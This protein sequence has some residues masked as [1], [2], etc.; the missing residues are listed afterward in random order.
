MSIGFSASPRF[1]I[2]SLVIG[3]FIAAVALVNAENCPPCYKDQNS[4]LSVAMEDGRS[5][6]NVQMDS[7]WNVDNA[8]NPQS[9]TNANIWN[10]VAGCEG[11]I[12][13]QGAAGMWNNAQ[14]TGG[15][16]IFFKF[17]RD[18][19]S[20]SPTII[21]KRGTP[22]NGGCASINLAPNGGP[23]EMTLP[24]ST[25]SMDLW[26]IVER[27]AHEFGHPIG[28]DNI[29]D[30]NCG[31]SSIMSPG[32]PNCTGQV[33]RSVTANDVDQSRK[34]HSFLTRPTV[35]QVHQEPAPSRHQRRLLVLAI[36]PG[37]R[38]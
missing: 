11:C 37:F 34:A 29:T 32:N 21:I 17:K 13:P 27:I 38:Q 35:K 9:S 14:G 10:G 4:P 7:S 28:L 22:A 24:L 36:A 33:G 23:Y 16:G 30:S 26:A 8:G 3:V 12:P 1:W 31:V 6:L 5:V 25:A 2:G 19:T 18:Q 15:N 20:T